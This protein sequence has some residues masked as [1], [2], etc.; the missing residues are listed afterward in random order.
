MSEVILLLIWVFLTLF[1]LFGGI[2]LDELFPVFNTGY[3]GLILLLNFF[4]S[5]FIGSI[6]G[7]PFG[8]I[9]RLLILLGMAVFLLAFEIYG[10][11]YVFWEFFQLNDS[12]W[13]VTGFLFVLIFVITFGGVSQLLLLALESARMGVDNYFNALISGV[14]MPNINASKSSKDTSSNFKRANRKAKPED[15]NLNK[16]LYK[17]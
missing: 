2:G 12:F 3:A 8:R 14:D 7:G 11:Y 6:V 16:D 9:N 17:Y 5:N 4:L 10:V 15:V 1:S 13:T